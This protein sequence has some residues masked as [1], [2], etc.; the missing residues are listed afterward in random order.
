MN[1]PR[2]IER[3]VDKF[4]TSALLRQAGLPTP[5]TVVCERAADAMAAVE[6]FGDAVIKPIFGSM[7]LGLVR[8][9][10]VEVARRVVRALEQSRAVF[11]VQR[12]GRARRT[13]PARVRGGRPR[14]RRDR[15]PGDRR[16]S[17]GPTSRWAAARAAVD[18]A[19]R[20]GSARGP[21]RR[22]RGRRLRRRGSAAVGRRRACSCSR[23]TASP[24]GRGCSAP[25]AS[26]W[27]RAG[28]APGVAR[29]LDAPGT[30]GGRR[31][32]ARPDAVC[33]PPTSRPPRSW[34]AG[35]RSPRRNPATSRPAVLSGTCGS[36][37][38][39]PAPKPSARR[40]STPRSVRSA[41]VVFE[42]V[43]ASM[44]AA[45]TNTNLGIV[46]LLAPL[47]RAAA[48]LRAW[49]APP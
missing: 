5:E 15:A 7:G 19:R 16:G 13:R 45:H 28:P 29:G 38:S 40:C 43:Q 42:A 39:W 6:A 34:P 27:R 10:D 44:R 2:A 46:L 20:V 14:G 3:A 37:T 30:S 31:G 18:A 4:Y 33:R 22:G 26:T 23:S 24:V 47:A 9:S 49:P 1:S 36:R 21:R 25:P 17:G 11:Y 12:C 35:S 41:S 48:I 8:V 32:A